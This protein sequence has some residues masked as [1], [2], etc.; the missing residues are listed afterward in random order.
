M[1]NRDNMH[2]FKPN[3]I[4]G[5]RLTLPAGIYEGR[6]INAKIDENQLGQALL[7]QVEIDNGDYTGFYRKQFESQQKSGS[8]YN[9]RYKGVYRVQLPDG[10]NTEHDNWRQHQLEGLAW[11]LEDGNPGYKWDFDETKLKGLKCGLNVRERDYYV[12]KRFGTTTEI[13]R[14]ESIKAVN[15]PDPAKRPKVMKKRELSH[16]DKVKLEQDRVGADMTAAGYTEVQ[17]DE[18]LPF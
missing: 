12:N 5:E 7:I 11:A 17:D 16:N 8:Q 10:K 1:I 2:N 15:D 13:G 6:I 14:L 9:V 18:Q 3:Q 4:T